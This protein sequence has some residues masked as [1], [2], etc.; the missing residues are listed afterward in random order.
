M[1]RKEGKGPVWT[2]YKIVCE[3]AQLVFKKVIKTFGVPLTSLKFVRIH[4]KFAFIC[5]PRAKPQAVCDFCDFSE[6]NSYFGTLNNISH[7]VKQFERIN[8]LL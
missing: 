8:L 4:K 3:R 1:C 6:Q 5:M 7:F 2:E